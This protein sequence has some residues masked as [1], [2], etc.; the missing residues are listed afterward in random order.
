MTQMELAKMN[1]ADDD[2]YALFSWLSGSNW[3][4]HPTNVLFNAVCLG[5]IYFSLK[6]RIALV[7]QVQQAIDQVVDESYLS[8]SFTIVNVSYPDVEA[9]G[10]AQAFEALVLD[11]LARAAIAGGATGI[12]SENAAVAMGE[13][14]GD[15]TLVSAT[16]SAPEGMTSAKL[17][18]VVCCYVELKQQTRFR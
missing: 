9:T 4:Y 2:G 18:Q 11:A 14:E 16:M 17:Q 10:S 5:F 7:E 8:M 3:S 12:T 6:K 13:G 1:V 15:S